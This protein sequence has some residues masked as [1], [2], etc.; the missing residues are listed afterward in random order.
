MPDS[1][2]TKAGSI[3]WTDL[4]VPDAT[5]IRAF[6]AGVTGWLEVSLQVS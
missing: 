2:K 1:P 5:A 3:V 4:T 6:Y